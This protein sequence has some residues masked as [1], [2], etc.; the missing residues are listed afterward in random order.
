MTVAAFRAWYATRPEDERWELIDGE[1]ERVP[2]ATLVHQ[3]IATELNFLLMVGLRSISSPPHV[4]AKW[5]RFADQGH[6]ETWESTARPAHSGSLGDPLCAGSAV[7][8]VPRA[9][10]E[11]GDPH[12]LGS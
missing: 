5:V 11:V 4:P 7:G 12:Y 2:P 6:A 3:L 8:A 9:G 1:P 10:V